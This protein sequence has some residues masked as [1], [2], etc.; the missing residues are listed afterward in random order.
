MTVPCHRLFVYGTL[1]RAS[2]HPMAA[3]LAQHGQFLGEARIPARLYDLGRYPG[4]QA[5]SGPDDW[6]YGD[7]YD[8]E[9]DPE[10]LAELDAYEAAESPQ[11]SFF[12]RALEKVIDAAGHSV[13]AWVY[14]FRG[15]VRPE[16]RV[17]S[18][19]YRTE[20]ENAS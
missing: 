15:D 4:M 2:R 10:A 18:G 9:A 19:R 13:E 8:L 7:L 20:P 3:F 5:P 14:W 6:V 16:Q 1:K 11:P 12:D 17:A